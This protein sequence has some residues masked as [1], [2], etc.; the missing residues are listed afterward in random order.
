MALDQ[1]MDEV[2]RDQLDAF[3]PAQRQVFGPGNQTE[4]GGLA[5][6]ILGYYAGDWRGY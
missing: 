2:M 4:A 1:V 6:V 3:A 5:F